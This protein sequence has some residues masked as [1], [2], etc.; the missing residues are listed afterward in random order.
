M[1][2]VIRS[3]SA[4]RWFGRAAIRYL[5]ALGVGWAAIAGVLGLFGLLAMDGDVLAGAMLLGRLLLALL[6]LPS[7]VLLALLAPWR[8]YEWH[9]SAVT[10]LLFAPVIVVV[11]ILGVW[12]TLGMI[13]FQIGFG[14]A[15]LPVPRLV[16]GRGR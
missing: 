16:V 11:L 6:A 12:W 13:L 4:T 8:E 5:A 7:L 14:A 2:V 10:I 9:Q 15:L 1:S 3:E